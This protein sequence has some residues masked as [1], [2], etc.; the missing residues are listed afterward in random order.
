MTNMVREVK[1]Q[2]GKKRLELIPL[3]PL[4]W[5]KAGIFFEIRLPSRERS[6]EG[7]RS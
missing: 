5:Y 6:K 7:M 3:M 2:K 4:V 1:T